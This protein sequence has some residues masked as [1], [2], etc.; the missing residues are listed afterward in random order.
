MIEIKTIQETESFAI[1]TRLLMQEALRKKYTLYYFPSSPSG[2][3]GVTRAVKDGKELFFKST[4]SIAAPFIGYSAADDKVQTYSLLASYGISMPYT[5]VLSVDDPIDTSLL[6]RFESLVVKPT[7]TNHG[8]GIT[9]GIT[10]KE[11]LG[12]AVEYARSA[13]V[14]GD[15]LIQEQVYGTEYRFLVVEGR[16]VAVAYR[17]P[18]FV[19]GDG[20]LTV[21]ELIEKKN[22][23]PRRGEGH[24]AELTLIAIDD[25][26]RHK[27]EQFLAMIP[28]KNH[29]VNVLETSNLSRGGESVDCTDIASRT[30]KRLAVEAANK[31][32]LQIAGVDIITRDVEAETDEGSYVIEV[33]VGPGL[34]MHQFPSSGEPRDV[35]RVIFRSMEKT[36]RPVDRVIRK[37]GRTESIGLPDLFEGRVLARID[38]GATTSSLW[39]SDIR[40]TDQGLE[41]SLFDP[42]SPDYTG[43][44]IV[45][46]DYGLRVVSSSMGHVQTRYQIRTRLKIKGRRKLARFTL[47]D[48]STQVYPVLIGRNV[49]R[50]SFVV[51]VMEGRPD[52]KAERNK[53]AELDAFIQM[54]NEEYK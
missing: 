28:E 21:L 41:F 23:D 53:R 31:C 7:D 15:T 43:K 37:V 12:R 16:V 44:R 6:R 26:R 22:Q 27:G 34:R 5:Q 54:R 4:C 19:I 14:T 8:D 17:R 2:G 1:S 9:V 30:L 10:T 39:A 35:A 45:V 46:A 47:A 33:N 52:R 48:R 32:F 24:S 36:A 49:L 11:Q 3:T 18:P 42:S 50:N 29:E 13:G 40:E 25:V 51:D 20:R 38:T